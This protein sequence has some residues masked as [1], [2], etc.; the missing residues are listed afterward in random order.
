MDGSKPIKKPDQAAEVPE[1]Q[2]KE[3][4]ITRAINPATDTLK[5]DLELA[6]AV[7]PVLIVIRGAVQGK[8]YSLKGRPYF[9]LGRD[10]SVELQI[11][12]ANVSRQH[13]KI[14]LEKDH[15]F[16]EDLGSRNGTFLN[17]EPIGSQKKMLEKEDMIKVGSTILKYLPAGTLETLY[18]I[19]LTNAASMDK[20]T[21][22]FNRKYISEVLEVEFKRAKA[23]HSEISIVMFDID[24]FKMVNDTYGHDCG[25]YVLSTL[26]QQVRNVGLRERD[27]AGRYGGEEFIVV[28]TNSNSSQAMDTA[29]RIRKKIEEFD[30]V[31]D[32]KRIPVTISLGVA[33]IKKDHHTAIDLYKAADGALYESKHAGKNRVS[34][35]P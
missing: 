29:E 11:D 7:D 4:T 28:L 32:G 22:L 15:L 27:L 23:L 3:I 18:H 30:F 12:D 10:K 21:G 9:L 17:D 6:K 19:N 2:Q 33:S 8:K 14:T 31:Y 24:N 16:I 5:I 34:L 20:L 26:G 13:A 25:D 1:G 35:A